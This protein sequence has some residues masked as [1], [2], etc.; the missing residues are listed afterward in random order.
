MSRRTPR[1]TLFPYTTLFRSQGRGRVARRGLAEVEL[2]LSRGRRLGLPFRRG[3]GAGGA[4][5]GGGR[6]GSLSV[7]W[8]GRQEIGRGDR[9][10]GRGVRLDMG[11]L[12]RHG[13]GRDRRAP[14][15]LTPRHL[16][17]PRLL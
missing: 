4:A 6:G 8:C 17:A 14:L 1:S 9:D 5:A 16:E 7:G 11:L 3:R 15:A 2:G 12:V 10:R 13:G